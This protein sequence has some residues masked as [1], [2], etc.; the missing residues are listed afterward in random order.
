MHDKYVEPLCL[1]IVPVTKLPIYAGSFVLVIL[2]AI[3]P[4]S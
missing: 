1:T 4:D 2:Y 3:V